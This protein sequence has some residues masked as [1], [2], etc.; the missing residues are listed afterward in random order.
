MKGRI[1]EIK[2]NNNL[3]D[4]RNSDAKRT[5][6]IINIT[7]KSKAKTLQKFLCKENKRKEY[8]YHIIEGNN[9]LKNIL[10]IIKYLIIIYS[11]SSIVYIKCNKRMIQSQNHF[12]IIKF[13]TPSYSNIISNFFNGKLPKEIYINGINQSE[14]KKAYEFNN[15]NNTIKMIY[16]NQLDST[17]KLFYNCRN[18]SE[19]DLSNF[20]ASKV[21]NMFMMFCGCSN[22][23]FLNLS[24]FNNQ[25]LNI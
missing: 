6:N 8:L 9:I 14:I 23:N 11:L 16:N 4:K 20:D 17:E 2:M 15:T 13:Y 18:I 24:N 19:I 25:V 22:L 21:T 3:Y 7:K 5:E 1:T 12:I 10:F